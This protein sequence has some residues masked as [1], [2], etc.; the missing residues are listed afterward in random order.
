MQQQ[1]NPYACHV[2]VCTN[3]RQGERKSCADGGTAALREL[4]K[5]GVE[6]RP[7]LR[8]RVRVSASGCLGRCAQGPNVLLHPPGLWFSGVMPADAE[9]LLAEIEALLPAEA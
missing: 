1:P 8:H 3:D 2:F 9:R 5:A 6:R 4:L 7:A